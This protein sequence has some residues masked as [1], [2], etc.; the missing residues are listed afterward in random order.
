MWIEELYDDVHRLMRWIEI[1]N[2]VD[3]MFRRGVLAVLEVSGAVLLI[4]SLIDPSFNL[5]AALVGVLALSV[6]SIIE[7]L[8]WKA[9]IQ[10][11]VT[12]RENLQLQRE[13]Q[14]YMKER[15]G[16]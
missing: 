14:R 16:L 7:Y 3:N 13:I 5:P 4:R 9:S 12:V 8:I 10:M 1:N 2:V 6:A 11:M 15:P